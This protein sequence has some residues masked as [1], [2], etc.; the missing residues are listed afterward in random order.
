LMADYA[1]A[2]RTRG[3]GQAALEAALSAYNTGDFH[4]GFEN[5]YVARYY[6]PSGVPALT[7]TVRVARTAAL[8]LIPA[9]GAE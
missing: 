1:A 7:N 8:N 6:G 4:R 9:V 2:V 3:E 5:G